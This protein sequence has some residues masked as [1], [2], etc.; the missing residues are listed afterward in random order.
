MYKNTYKIVNIQN[1]VLNSWVLMLYI[2]L[3]Y[4]VCVCGGGGGA[5]A[6]YIRIDTNVFS[7]RLGM[8]LGL[9]GNS[10]LYRISCSLRMKP[11]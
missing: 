6:Y 11:F 7:Q 10:V 5:G 3:L 9:K 4:V 1:C 2:S 8:G